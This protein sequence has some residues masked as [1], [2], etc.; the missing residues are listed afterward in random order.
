[1]TAEH[2]PRSSDVWGPDAISL[3]IQARVLS[4]HKLDHWFAVCNGK[5]AGRGRLAGDLFS[6]LV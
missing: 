1:M 2:R 3:A 5:L 4:G 6:R